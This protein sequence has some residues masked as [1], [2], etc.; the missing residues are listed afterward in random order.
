MTISGN[1]P[2]GGP[3]FLGCAEPPADCRLIYT[4]L[5]SCTSSVNTGRCYSGQAAF[6]RIYSWDVNT[7]TQQETL[8]PPGTAV[9]SPNFAVSENYIILDVDQTVTGVKSIA[10]YGYTDISGIPSDTTFDGQF[11]DY[12]NDNVRFF[13]S[14]MEAVTD[15]KFLGLWQQAAASDGSKIIEW[16]LSGTTLSYNV[17]IEVLQQHGY[18]LTGD[19]LLTY[20]EDGTPNKIIGLGFI[21]PLVSNGQQGFLLQFDYETNVLE[22]VLDLP[23]GVRGGASLGIYD[24]GIYIA[25]DNNSVSQPDLTGVWRLDIETQQWT[26]LP[27]EDVPSTFPFP[28]GSSADFSATPQCRISNGLVFGGTTTTTTTDPNITTTTTTTVPSGVRTIFTH[29]QG[30]VNN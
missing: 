26:K 22:G 10:R 20:K 9:N 6:A 5:D 30:I 13:G 12:P 4:V 1:A 25:P 24:G 2:T 15:T 19:L 28:S 18:Y 7:N 8:L 16:D 17:K 23:A 3:L 27:D 21:P 14:V 11:I 29:F